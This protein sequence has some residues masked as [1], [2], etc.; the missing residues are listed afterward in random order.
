MTIPSTATKAVGNK[1]SAAWANGNVKDP[2]DFLL[3]PPRCQVSNSVGHSIGNN[4]TVTLDFDTEAYDTAS[5][6]DNATNNSR[7][8]IPETGLYVVRMYVRFAAAGVTFTRARLQC[9]VDGTTAVIN[10]ATSGASAVTDDWFSV[11]RTFERTFTAGQYLELLVTQTS[12]ASR[13]TSAGNNLT[14]MTV[15]FVAA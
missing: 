11:E 1:V 15:R 12:G 7:I 10:H 3:N 13:T 2:I 8:T 6:H 5:M 14:G 9:R 4:A